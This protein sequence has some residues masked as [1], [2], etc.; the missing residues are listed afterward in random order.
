MAT[1]QRKQILERIAK[2]SVSGSGNSLRDSRGRLVVKRMAL[3]DG[4]NGTRFVMDTIVALCAKIPVTS[5]K[6]GQPLDITPHT[7]GEEVNFVWMLDK[8]ESA[9]GNIKDLVLKLFGEAESDPVELVESLEALTESNAGVGM[10][11]DYSTV[12]KETKANKVE[13][14]IPKWET[15]E[16]QNPEHYKKWMD[17]LK[18]AAQTQPAQA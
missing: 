8:H 17:S 14:V 4:F 6:T 9:M 7:V 15:V 5:I 2:S 12:R 10:V 3:E 1:G 11:I 13:I 16:Q 18:S